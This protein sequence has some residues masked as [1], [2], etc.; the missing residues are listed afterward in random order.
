MRKFL[1]TAIAALTIGG[2]VVA[3][4]APA[5][6]QP[7][8]YYGHGGYYHGGYGYY[9]GGNNA[10]LAAAA[11]VA[12]LALGAALGSTAAHNSYYNGGYYA[13]PA[14]YPAYYG[15]YPAYGYGYGGYRV[16]E[17]Q[18]LVWDPYIGRNVVVAN[19]Y[20]C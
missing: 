14:A 10:G 20:A 8:R 6:A 13:A 5:D 1:T 9:H 19:R 12:G 2:A 16:C 11:G 18:R 7:Y 15:A 17:S 4:A 3:A